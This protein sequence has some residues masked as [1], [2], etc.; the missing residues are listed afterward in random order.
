MFMSEHGLIDNGY[1]V[2]YA[3]QHHPCE[4]NTIDG[5]H[6]SQVI[7][8]FSQVSKTQLNT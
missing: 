6:P 4:T 7:A 1:S 5:L 2:Q 3:S 8:G